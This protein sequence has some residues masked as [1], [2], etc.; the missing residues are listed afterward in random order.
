MFVFVL[1][2]E[3]IKVSESSGD[4]E[5][6]INRR[7]RGERR[8]FSSKRLKEMIHFKFISA[9]LRPRGSLQFVVL[10]S[11]SSADEDKRVTKEEA[12]TAEIFRWTPLESLSVPANVGN[13]V[14]FYLALSAF[15]L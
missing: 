11:G 9:S 15:G 3:I 2:H 5:K 7:V 10:F 4:E 14:A 8:A 12:E 1:A 6:N 13:G